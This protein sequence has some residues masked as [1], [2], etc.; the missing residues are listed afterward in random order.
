MNAEVQPMFIVL[1]GFIALWFFLCTRMFKILRTRH[2]DVYERMGSPSLIMN[3][4]ISSNLKFMKFLFTRRWTRMPDKGLCQLG[5]FMLAVF[6]IYFAL[7]FS[8][9][10]LATSG[11]AQ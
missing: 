7:L 8:F 5:D 4:T 3:N 2:P 6:V 9:G 10:Y 1:F 11:N